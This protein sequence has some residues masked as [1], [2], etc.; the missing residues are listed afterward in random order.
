[1]LLS[2]GAVDGTQPTRGDTTGAINE[3]LQSEVSRLQEGCEL[4][5]CRKKTMEAGAAEVEARAAAANDSNCASLD[6]ETVKKLPLLITP[7][8]L[9][10]SLEL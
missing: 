1:V 2:L 4:V 7:A 9:A 5:L 6:G 3:G 10:L 8:V